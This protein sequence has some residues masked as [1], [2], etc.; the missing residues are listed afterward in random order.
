MKPIHSEE[1]FA[2]LSRIP[3]QREMKVSKN[4]DGKR[5]VTLMCAA[6]TDTS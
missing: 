6:T 5:G 4:V 2:E 1:E 3:V